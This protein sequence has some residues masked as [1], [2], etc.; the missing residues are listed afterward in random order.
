MTAAAAMGL[1]EFVTIRLGV[2]PSLAIATVVYGVALVLTGTIG[3][4]E[5]D[6]AL[7]V[8]GRSSPAVSQT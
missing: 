8:I 7:T 6:I 3:R 5:A 1:A 4:R 2:I